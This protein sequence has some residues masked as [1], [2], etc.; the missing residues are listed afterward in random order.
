MAKPGLAEPV[1]LDSELTVAM[2]FREI[3][4]EK[5]KL[6]AMTA[7]AEDYHLYVSVGKLDGTPTLAL[8]YDNDDGHRR[9]KIGAIILEPRR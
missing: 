2:G 1:P 8:P 9:Y 5:E 6:F 7:H 3:F 4:K